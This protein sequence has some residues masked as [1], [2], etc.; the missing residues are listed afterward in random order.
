MTKN[1]LY[2]FFIPVVSRC[3]W[4]RNRVFSIFNNILS[5]INTQN[6]DPFGT[7]SIWIYRRKFSSSTGN[8]VA[9]VAVAFV[10]MV[11]AV[12]DLGA[13]V[14]VYFP[15]TNSFGIP[16]CWI[17]VF[18]DIIYRFDSK[19]LNSNQSKPTGLTVENRP[20][21]FTKFYRTIYKWAKMYLA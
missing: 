21:T 5:N 12:R 6:S 18:F 15:D 4:L 14:V 3:R 2:N 17:R 11:T 1:E 16:F 9:D 20:K 19:V 13:V 8:N 10:L 7:L